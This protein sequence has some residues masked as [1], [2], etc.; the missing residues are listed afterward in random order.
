MFAGIRHGDVS[1][2]KLYILF[3][4]SLMKLQSQLNNFNTMLIQV[5]VL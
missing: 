1:K 3:E 4:K 5:I 2:I